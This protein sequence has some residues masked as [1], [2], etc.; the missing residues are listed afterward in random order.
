MEGG[1]NPHSDPSQQDTL[2]ENEPQDRPSPQVQ[3]STARDETPP[4]QTKDKLSPFKQTVRRLWEF[5]KSKLARRFKCGDSSM[6][7]EGLFDPKVRQ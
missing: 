2:D 1:T 3:D 4:P 7:S 6:H 5:M